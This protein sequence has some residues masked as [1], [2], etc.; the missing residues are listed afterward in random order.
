MRNLDISFLK[1]ILNLKNDE[2]VVL[3]GWPGMGKTSFVLNLLVNSS[4]KGCY[5]SLC[6]SS[7]EIAYREEKMNIYAN[8]DK[9]KSICMDRPS[10]LELLELIVSQKDNFDY[11]VIDDMRG[12]SEDVNPLFSED[13]NYQFVV[14]HLKLVAKSLCSTIILVS[15]FDKKIGDVFDSSRFARKEKYIDHIIIINR[16]AYYGIRIDQFHGLL[17]DE[18]AFLYVSKTKTPRRTGIDLRLKFNYPFWSFPEK[19][20]DK[21]DDI[22]PF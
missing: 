22:V 14:R 16:P 17:E 9:Y 12:L 8:H 5:I 20:V 3:G 11:F 6:E 13:K 1:G 10:I 2:L 7:E 18:D 21:E 4:T 19:K 15:P